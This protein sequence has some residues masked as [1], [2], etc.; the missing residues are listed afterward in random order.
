MGLLQ[1]YRSGV[2]VE[3][4]GEVSD[5][6]DRL[7]RNLDIYS[8]K[9][10]RIIKDMSSFRRFAARHK[11]ED[12]LFKEAGPVI[13]GDM[14]PWLDRVEKTL[15]E[16]ASKRGP[17]SPLTKLHAFSPEQKLRIINLW[18]QGLPP[19]QVA[20]DLS[21]E[22]LQ[23]QATASFSGGFAPRQEWDAAVAASGYGNL[24]PDLLDK[25]YFLGF[26]PEET[27]QYAPTI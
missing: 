2:C 12:V 4:F 13:Y 19:E 6:S 7:A 24:A 26:T 10:F 27:I 16:I 9:Y 18:K 22:A 14:D 11:L 15:S 20:D 3:K 23:Q 17:Y 1:K 8:W 21:Q 25:F 5:F